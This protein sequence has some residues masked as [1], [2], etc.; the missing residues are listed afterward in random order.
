MKRDGYS[1][2]VQVPCTSSSSVY[3]KRTWQHD[4]HGSLLSPIPMARLK[5]LLPIHAAASFLHGSFSS[6]MPER[7]LDQS[8]QFP[9]VL[10]GVPLVSRQSGLWFFF[11]GPPLSVCNPFVYILPPQAKP[12]SQTFLQVHT[13]DTCPRTPC[14][15]PSCRLMC[16]CA[17]PGFLGCWILL[18][19]QHLGLYPYCRHNRPK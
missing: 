4:M 8:K 16:M 2:A 18:P 10:V 9:F 12:P 14:Y 6:S 13:I 11:L 15:L 1:Q 3:L 19:S 17:L 5:V 7:R